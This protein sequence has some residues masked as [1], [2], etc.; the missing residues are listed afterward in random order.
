[1]RVKFS[2]DGTTKNYT[3]MTAE[4][5]DKIARRRFFVKPT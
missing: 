4:N 3:T 5:K 2:A 1:M